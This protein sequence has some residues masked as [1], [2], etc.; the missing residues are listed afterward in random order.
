LNKSRAPIAI[1]RGFFVLILDGSFPS[2]CTSTMENYWFGRIEQA[3]DVL[4]FHSSSFLE[5]KPS[6]LSIEPYLGLLLDGETA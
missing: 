4:L 6:R 5:E 2:K 1:G 3:Q